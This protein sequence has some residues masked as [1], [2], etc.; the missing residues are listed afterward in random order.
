MINSY[1][2][3]MEAGK[4]EEVA[5]RGPNR[6]PGL[7]KALLRRFGMELETLQSECGL[8]SIQIDIRR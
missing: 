3:E 4:E 7:M 1:L 5:L 8:H 6:N 2:V